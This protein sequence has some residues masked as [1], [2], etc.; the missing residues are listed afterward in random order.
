MALSYG[1]FLLSL[2]RDYPFPALLDDPLL[3]QDT[4]RQ[5]RSLDI[6][7]EISRKRQVILLSHRPFSRRAGERLIQ[8]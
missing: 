6:L 1:G 5:E 4:R 7:R 3:T 2:D 8:L